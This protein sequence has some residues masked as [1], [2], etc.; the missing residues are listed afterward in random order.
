MLA[1]LGESVYI[2]NI[3]VLSPGRS[4]SKTFAKACEHLTNFTT[5]HE[6]RADLI[7]DSRFAYPDQHIE[8]DNRLT[9]ML[10]SLAE[11]YKGRE[12]LFVNLRRNPQK[13]AESFRQRWAKSYHGAAIMPAFAHGIIMRNRQWPRDA[14]LNVCKFYVQVVTDNIEQFIAPYPNATVQ[15]D[16]GGESFQRF[17]KLIEAEGDLDAAMS[18]WGAVHNESRFSYLR[19]ITQ[20]LRRWT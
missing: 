16:D 2:M 11:H 6:T 10:G 4:G 15:I 5:G 17:L 13:V 18:T 8:A 9:W 12:I 14:R 1:T 7:G 3:F 20:I 19:R